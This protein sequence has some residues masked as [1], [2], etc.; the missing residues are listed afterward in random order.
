MVF[1]VIT[2]QT[3]VEEF[4]NCF[5]P[6]TIPW[7]INPNKLENDI[8]RIVYLA[9]NKSFII[10]T[11]LTARL[12]VTNNLSISSYWIT[13]SGIKKLN[14]ESFAFSLKFPTRPLSQVQLPQPNM[15]KIQLALVTIAL[16]YSYFHSNGESSR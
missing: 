14:A 4:L 1:Y 15:H 6:E 12:I 8:Q 2:L 10:K 3:F 11:Q 16:I 9:I 5:Y 13:F 7:K